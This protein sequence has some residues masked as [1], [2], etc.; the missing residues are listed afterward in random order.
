MTLILAE[1]DQ[2]IKPCDI[3]TT[4]LITTA[5]AIYVQFYAILLPV[6]G[7]LEAPLNNTVTTTL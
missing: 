3:I 1:R 5:H 6:C 2:F 7:W 4:H